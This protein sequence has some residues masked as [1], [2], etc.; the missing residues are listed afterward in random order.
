MTSC[1]RFWMQFRT[2]QWT[3]SP[4]FFRLPTAS[5]M[6]STHRYRIPCT[7]SLIASAP[8]HTSTCPALTAYH[9]SPA[10]THGNPRR[11]C[12]RSRMQRHKWRRGPVRFAAPRRKRSAQFR[13][14]CGTPFLTVSPVSDPTALEEMLKM[15]LTDPDPDA[16]FVRASRLPFLRNGGLQ[17]QQSAKLLERVTQEQTLNC[18]CGHMQSWVACFGPSFACS[19]SSFPDALSAGSHI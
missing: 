14:L 4:R 13:G 8:S 9:F 6:P 16:R 11:P 19:G 17:E 3:T 15:A 5:T 18:V 12:Q 10:T 1:L 2:H 7:Q